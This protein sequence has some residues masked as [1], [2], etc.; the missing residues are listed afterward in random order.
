M[1]DALNSKK[2]R[3]FIDDL[4]SYNTEMTY[5]SEENFLAYSDAVYNSSEGGVFLTEGSKGGITRERA[6]D[7]PKVLI[8]T[9]LDL[10]VYPRL[11]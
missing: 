3:D 11:W 4:I 5:S 7:Y 1:A 9:G 2:C 6:T 8:P 10:G